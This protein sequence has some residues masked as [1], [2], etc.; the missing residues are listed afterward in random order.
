MLQITC[1]C[2]KFAD[3]QLQRNG[4][5]YAINEIHTL[6]L[7]QSQCQ[8]TSLFYNSSVHSHAAITGVMHA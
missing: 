2:I 5:G 7:T 3:T 4:T 8:T 6:Y 1:S